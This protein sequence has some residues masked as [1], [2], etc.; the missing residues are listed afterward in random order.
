MAEVKTADLLAKLFRLDGKVALI[1][2]G[3]G[4]IGEAA[5]RG[6][7]AVGATVVVAGR[8]EQRAEDLA[9][10]LKSEGYDAYA[11]PFD[12]NKNKDIRRMVDETA[13]QLGSIDILVNCVGLNREEKLLDVTEENFDYV[14]TAN[15]KS[16]FFLAQ[17]AAKYQIAKGKGGKQVHLGSVRTQLGLRGRGYAAYVAAKGGLGIMCKQ[18]AAE[19]APDNINVNVVAP[20]FVRTEQVAA[21][22]ADPEFYN[23]LTARIPLG[24]IA[25]PDD[26]MQAIL[27]FVSSASDFI[28]GQTLYLDGGITAT[29]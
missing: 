6:L 12:A 1:T 20:T 26:V 17:A 16:A 9:A 25:E 29:Q 5:C 24:R 22:L 11:A 7:A 8:N 4:G 23:A 19:L 15:L 14:Y 28:T 10:T 13:S 3:Y 2:G 27:F 18:L 21:M